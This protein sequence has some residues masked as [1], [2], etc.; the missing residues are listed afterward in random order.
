MFTRKFLSELRREALRRRVWWSALDVLERGILT[1]STKIIT[2]VKSPLL[3]SQLLQIITK[4]RKASH[5]RLANRIREFGERK[6][7]EISLIGVRFYSNLAMNW[8]DE[9]FSRYLAF[10]SLNSPIGWS[11]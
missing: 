5:G 6:A 7:K 1:A 8:V 9:D 3:N 11:T 2:G 4:I 10:M